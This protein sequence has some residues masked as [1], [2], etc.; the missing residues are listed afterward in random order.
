MSREEREKALRDCEE[1]YRQLFETMVLGVVYQDADGKITSANPAAQRILGLTLDQLQGKTS[2]DPSWQ[3][4]YEDGSELPGSEHPAMVALR[5]GKKVGSLI[6]GVC[7]SQTEDYVWL[8]IN[9]IPLFKPGETA[10]YQV[11]TTF[12]DITERKKAVEAL[13]ESE[14]FIKSVMDNLPIGIAV[15]TLDPTVKFKYMNEN[16]AKFYRSTKEKLFKKD[17]FWEAVY[18]DIELRENIK[19]RVLDDCA[20][21]DPDK[22]I[23]ENVPV[24]RKGK[25]TF[26]ISATNIPV[27]GKPLMIS[28]VQDVTSL[29]KAEE[30]LHK[31]VTE[32]E[33]LNKIAATL[34]KAD[35]LDEM[36]PILLDETLNALGVEAGAIC[37][38][39]PEHQVL[40]F[41]VNR[42]WLSQLENVHWRID[43]GIVGRVFSSE[44]PYLTPDV[45]AGPLLKAEIPADIP[46]G[47]SGAYL[48][49]I[50]GSTAVGLL[51]VSAAPPRKF[52]SKELDLLVPLAEM[53]GIAIHRL[54]LHEEV[55]RQLHQLRST[56]AVD[57][58]ISSSLDLQLTMNVLLE[59][60]SAQPNVD[61]T[62]LFLLHPTLKR[63]EFASGRGLDSK[64]FEK[65]HL[66]IGETAI[67]K[68]VRERQTIVVTG[69]DETLGEECA[70]MFRAVS[71][72]GCINFPLITKG[73]VTG[74]LTI[75]QH[76]TGQPESGWLDFL[77]TLAGQ[78]AIAIESARLFES[79]QRSNLELS[80]AYDATIE[81]WSRALDLRDHVTEDHSQRVTELAVSLAT[82]IGIPSSELIHVRRGAL[83]HDIGKV[84]IPDS[85]LL[86]PGKL[87]E[88]DWATMKRHPTIAYELLYPIKYL[89]PALDIPR[90]HHEKFD[91]SGYPRGLQGEDIPLAARIFAVIDVYDALTSD[92]PYRKAWSEADTLAHLQAE[93]GSHFDPQVVEYF[94]EYIAKPD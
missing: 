64:L 70:K 10:P 53:A 84:G 78:A 15:N 40:G 51:I 58:A 43:E 79:L 5:T 6:M 17:N 60:V 91:G 46:A 27:P 30:A 20:S 94:L 57:K 18:E 54:S 19:Q 77:E 90:C 56:R 82:V 25:D 36:L 87:T 85:I 71:F 11:Y 24:T 48:P 92:R 14:A 37:L 32:L 21:G 45:S 50:T 34:R 72:A 38:F 35:T 74:V 44:E 12:E 81:G 69:N 67:G 63:L 28:T 47:W 61:A 59:H 88:E 76:R 41:A 66:S 39:Q 75:F 2:M 42:G 23:W 22:M 62:A 80:L 16:F 86:K 1:K 8:S 93:S 55:K 33:A 4:I 83:L 89:R 68:A 29:K 65:M 26:Y 3:A 49:I 7:H 73:E 52:S 31:H 9:A 13:R